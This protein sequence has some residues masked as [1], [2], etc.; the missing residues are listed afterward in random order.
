[1]IRKAEISDAA[2]IASIYNR[3]VTGTDITFEEEPVPV[4]EMAARI[5]GISSCF[6]YLV[7][8]EDGEVLGYCY[9]H[10]W[11][12]RSAYRYTA[13]TTV[14]LAPCAVGRGIGTALM[15]HLVAECRSI[16]LKALVACITDGNAAS[17][18]LHEKLG[19]RQ[20]SHFEKVG[21]KFGRW[22]D[23]VDYELIL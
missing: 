8:E 6:P 22:L 4:D 13:E 2:A 17:N 1:M 14:Y 12:G 23:V 11:K 18:A 20:A 16:G 10:A 19:F 7:W 15:S 3:Y 21:M 5:A 9:A